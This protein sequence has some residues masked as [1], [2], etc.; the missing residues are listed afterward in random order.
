MGF[1]LLPPKKVPGEKDWVYGI[2]SRG[3]RISTGDLVNIDSPLTLM[4]GSGLYSEEEEDL[5]YVEPVYHKAHEDTMS[6]VDD[7][8]EVKLPE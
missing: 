5:D 7:F 1:R 8:E 2:I 3:R 4:I 6:E